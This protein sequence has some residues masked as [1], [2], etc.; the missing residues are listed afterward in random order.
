VHHAEAL[1]FID[2]DHAEVFEND[3]FLQQPMRADHD[4]DL[5]VGQR[6]KRGLLFFLGLEAREFFDPYRK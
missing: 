5:A 4:I 6:R 1:F 3:V 2:D